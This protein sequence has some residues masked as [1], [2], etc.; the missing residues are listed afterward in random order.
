[1][2]PFV[3]FGSTPIKRNAYW[4]A[5]L[6]LTRPYLGADRVLEVGA[7]DALRTS[8]M[9]KL[10]GTLY[11]VELR[12]DRIPTHI[13]HHEPIFVNANGELL[14]FKSAVFDGVIAHHVIEH[15]KDDISFIREI[16]RVLKKGGFAILGTPN[17]KRLPRFLAEMFGPARTFPWW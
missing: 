3:A 6:D 14:P 12:L 7:S 10:Y 9:M 4:D 11:C 15:I 17:R 8:Q 1:M 5:F 2:K 13:E 16:H